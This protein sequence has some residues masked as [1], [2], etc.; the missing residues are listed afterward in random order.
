MLVILGLFFTRSSNKFEK[1]LADER[2]AEVVLEKE[3]AKKKK[4][5]EEKAE[6]AKKKAVGQSQKEYVL[7]VSECVC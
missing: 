7:I 4:E 1:L 6:K 2:T 5:A 3:E